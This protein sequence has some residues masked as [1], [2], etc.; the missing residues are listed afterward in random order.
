M[1]KDD[2]PLVVCSD[3]PKSIGKQIS[4]GRMPTFY[5]SKCNICGGY[6]VC[7][8]PRDYGHFSE[9]E[10]ERMRKNINEEV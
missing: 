8:E 10:L 4:A 9:L 7:T 6:K 3:C 2:Y 5:M 1:R